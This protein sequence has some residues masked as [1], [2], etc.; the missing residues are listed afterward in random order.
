MEEYWDLYDAD[1]RP[2]GKK[3]PRGTPLP[4]GACHLIVHLCIFN[5]K[6]EML[7]QRRADDK[8]TFPSKWD[9]SVGGSA[10]AGEDSRQA[11]MRE[12]R[13]ELGF[14]PLLSDVRPYIT[15]HFE[16]GFDDVYIATCRGNELSLSLQASEVA[17]TAWASEK[18]ICALIRAGDFIPY[19][20][21]YVGLLFC[22]LHYRG[23]FSLREVAP[24]SVH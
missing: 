9:F 1:R 22:C 5:E 13:E 21:P 19:H 18:E 24:P 16:G 14:L 3:H 11:I 17:G 12:C 4:T 15:V 7:I 6:G 20:I 23:N 2:L 8:D 10:V